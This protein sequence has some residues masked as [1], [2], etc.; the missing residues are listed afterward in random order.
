MF[1]YLVLF[2]G[3]F[4]FHVTKI[5]KFIKRLLSVMFTSCSANLVAINLMIPHR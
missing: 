5:T 2:V 4:I 1:L 3:F